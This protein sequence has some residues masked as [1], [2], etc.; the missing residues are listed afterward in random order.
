MRYR[1]EQLL[2]YL[3]ERAAEPGTWQGIAF[4]LTLAGSKYAELDWGRCATLG[5]IASAAIKII[6]P[7]AQPPKE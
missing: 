1:L 6:F 3:A 4:V 5:G 2:A 7:D